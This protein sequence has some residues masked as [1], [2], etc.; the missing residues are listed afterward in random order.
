MEME[1][2]IS[3]EDIR[4]RVKELG[5]QISQDYRG[6]EPIMIGILNGVIFFFSDLVLSLDIPVKIDFIRAASYGASM[7]SS[8]DIKITKDVELPVSGQ[9]II[10]VEDIID[11]GLTLKVIKDRLR[12]RGA[13]SVRICV[14][15]DKGER[16]KERIYIDYCGFKIPEGF[17]VGYGLDFN[18]RY[19]YLPGIFKLKT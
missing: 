12:Q 6:K 14:L 13:S 1:C 19:R 17:L 15:I 2:L 10:L 7:E 9:D 3:L 4:K 18:E 11:T 5:I 16:R 8:G